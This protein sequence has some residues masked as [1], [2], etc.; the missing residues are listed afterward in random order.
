MPSSQTKRDRLAQVFGQDAL[1]LCRAACAAGAPGWIREVESVRL[2][3][4][5]LVQ[6]CYESRIRTG[7]AVAPPCPD[8]R[9]PGLRRPVPPAG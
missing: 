9:V 3:R 4:K 6:T 5:I 1:A 2:L 7:T 8:R